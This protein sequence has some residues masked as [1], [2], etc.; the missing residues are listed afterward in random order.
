MKR[1][2][3]LNHHPSLKWKLYHLYRFFY[4][5]VNYFGKNSSE[6]SPEGLLFIG[7]GDFRKVGEEFFSHFQNLCNLNPT[8]KILDIGC[9]QGRMAVPLTKF[10]ESSGAY[11]GFDIFQSGIEWCKKNI[12]TRYS[13]FNFQLVNIYNKE[14]NPNGKIQPSDF[15]FPYESNYFDFIFATSVFTHMLPEDLD[16][17]FAE[18]NR[19][20]K[21][22][23]KCLLTFLLLNSQS[24]N[25]IKLKKSK[26][27][28]EYLDENYYLM[29]RDVPEHTIAYKEKF[30]K[31]IYEKHGL[32]IE[33][34]I[35]YGSWSGR[36]NFLSF[37][38]LIISIKPV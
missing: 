9:G 36:E 11:E 7:S 20:L 21:N 8:D 27:E 10:L 16:N 26:I 3:F 32:I 22:N 2:K 18:I 1:L 34:P 24:Q 35:R 12:S 23:G 19:V 28:F 5:S 38:D 29:Y 13:N 33:E 31:E 4:D 37:Q 6:L 30:I 17:Y 15:K 25:S 14:Y